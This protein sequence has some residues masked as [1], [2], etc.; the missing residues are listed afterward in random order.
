MVEVGVGEHDGVERR[1]V[2]RRLGSSCAGGAPDALE[3]P[4]VDQH[5]GLRRP[6]EESGTGHGAGPTEELQRSCSCHG[7]S[8]LRLPPAEEWPKTLGVGPGRTYS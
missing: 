8:V 2:D 3:Q 7:R 1:R 5:V 6:D 4:A